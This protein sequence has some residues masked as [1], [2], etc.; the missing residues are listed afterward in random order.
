MDVRKI[1]ANSTGN[2][3]KIIIFLPPIFLMG[4]IFLASSI[5]AH[6]DSEN[7]NIMMLINPTF[8]NILHVPLFGALSFLWINSLTKQGFA[9]GASI[10]IAVIIVFAYGCIDEF[11]Q[12]F[13]PGRFCSVIDMF[14][15]YIGALS[16]I[17]FFLLYRRFTK[18]G[19]GNRGGIL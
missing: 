16:G 3:N 18:N 14:F 1:A 19:K 13:V 17:L 7:M 6:D 12:Y 8:Q 4:M 10:I 9:I 15:N 5:P 11:H 2:Q